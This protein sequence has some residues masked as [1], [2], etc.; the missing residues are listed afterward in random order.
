[1]EALLPTFVAVLVA[2]FGGRIQSES[3]ALSRRY[4]TQLPL[5]QAILLASL[6]GAG[7]AAAGG[8]M[9]AAQLTYQA[10]T[11]LLGVALVFSAISL[12]WPKRPVAAVERSAAF[13]TSLWRIGK[14]VMAGNGLFLI[15]AFSARGN[16]P[17]TAACA[18][19][20]ALVIGSLPA[21]MVPDEWEAV[22]RNAYARRGAGLLLL[23]LGLYAGLS[24]LRLI[25]L[26]D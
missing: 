8:I 21:L 14:A 16:A 22:C 23:L 9:V 6:A 26:S 3:T 20:A 7:L 4:E 2:E 19:A 25:G 10:R 15:F 12:L 24:A 5:L 1:M 18:G 11:L 13:T 17:V